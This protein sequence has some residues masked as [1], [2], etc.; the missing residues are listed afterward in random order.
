MPVQRPITHVYQRQACAM[1]SSTDSGF[2][3][4]VQRRRQ[5]H[6]FTVFGAICELGLTAVKACKS[7]AR[8]SH[9]VHCS[10]VIR[11]FMMALGRDH[12]DETHT[13][14]LILAQSI[15]STRSG[16][17]LRRWANVQSCGQRPLALRV[18]V[19]QVVNRS[20]SAAHV[21]VAHLAIFAQS[22]E[23]S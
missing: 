23:L 18:T 1:M 7:N 17:A 6:L 9:E 22:N 21:D 4:V 16:Q 13:M 14:P 5:Y 8:A 2:Q 3:H 20:R 11:I 15:F 19:V 10:G 12:H